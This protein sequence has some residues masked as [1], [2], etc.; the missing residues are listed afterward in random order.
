MDR[1]EGQATLDASE[2]TPPRSFELALRHVVEGTARHTG[3]AFFRALVR[4]LAEVLG[5]DGAWVT[6]FDAA[7]R[8]LR[9]FAFYHRGGWIDGYEYALD[10]T[11]CA[12][13]IETKSLFCVPERL[14]ELYPR[15][16]DLAPLGAVSYLG[17][18]LLD[19]NDQIMGHLAV[20]DSQPMRLT[21]RARGLFE[22]FAA[23][24]T[25]ELTRLQADRKLRQQER[26]FAGVVSSAM[27]TIVELDAELRIKLMNPA[28]HEAFGCDASAVLEQPFDQFLRDDAT[29][30]VRALAKEL[31]H[32]PP[33]DRQRWIAG[34]N[35][36]R[37][38]GSEFVAEATMS[39]LEVEHEMRFTLILRDVQSRLDAEQHIRALTEERA[40]LLEELDE[41]Y[42]VS[43]IIGSSE[44]M[45]AVMDDIGRVAP[46]DS[47]VL[48]LGESGTGKELFARAVHRISKRA[49]K[50]L[51]KLNCAALPAHL[52]ESDLFGHEKGAFTGAVS[53]RR[54]RFAMADGGTIFLD[55]IGELPLELQA[56][57]LRV[58]QEGEFEPVGGARTVT[59]DVRVVAATNRDLEAMVRSGTFRED[60]FYRLFVFPV[61]I[62][63]LRERGE[64]IV[65]LAENFMNEY[66]RRAGC[67]LKPLSLEQRTR[68]ARYQWPGNVRELQ[69]VIDR[70]V[71]LSSGDELGLDRALPGGP[72]KSRRT[73]SAPGAVQEVL[74]DGQVRDFERANT[75]RALRVCEGRVS[76]AGGAAQLL[77][78]RPS[79]LASRLKS[80]GIRKSDYE[81][82]L[83][84]TPS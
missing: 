58:L 20:L 16:P 10:G 17:A 33:A 6:E 78:V 3:D 9:A 60:L 61:R 48:L 53:A 18:P 68:L 67:V 41:L 5:V 84:S 24:A 34:L 37:A 51:I 77:G 46:T 14:V 42:H 29:R 79:T 70:A 15:D 32:G 2:R 55:E 12:P 71:I 21:E 44:P 35:A 75:L 45:R 63:A 26:Q 69:N 72:E 36:R 83:S 59:V 22:I 23:R 49:E 1:S 28:G 30:R 82:S 56:K 11:P 47:T 13:V 7:A 66:A 43:G 80:L 27:D 65:A 81:T 57:L 74:T 62:P 73:E 8:R 38:D 50:P 25:A 19:T 40:V 31:T 39:Q 52:V 54:G 76:G 4:N 64:D